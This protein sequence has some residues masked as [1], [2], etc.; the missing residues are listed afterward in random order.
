MSMLTASAMLG[1]E[2][3]IVGFLLLDGYG[4]GLEGLTLTFAVSGVIVAVDFLFKVQ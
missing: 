3:S 1:L 2:I 4:S